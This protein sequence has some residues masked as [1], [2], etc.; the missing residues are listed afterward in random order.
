MVGAAIA[1]KATELGLQLV[2][3]TGVVIFIM[4]V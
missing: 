3:L 4:V 1:R 2:F